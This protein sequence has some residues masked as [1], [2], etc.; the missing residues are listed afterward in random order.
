MG[1]S[2]SN[3]EFFNNQIENIKK[4]TWKLNNIEI[5]TDNILDK[6]LLNFN[7]DKKHL[8]SIIKNYQLNKLL[9]D[10]LNKSKFFKRKKTFFKK[11]YNLIINSDFNYSITRE[12]FYKKIEKD[13]EG[14]A[15]TT[16]IKH[17]KIF[18]HSAIQIFT[19]LGPIA[20]LPVSNYET[21]VVYSMN[22]N[23]FIDDLEIKNLIKNFNLK[24]Q[25]NKIYKI[26]KFKLKSFQLR[27]YYNHNILAF[28]DLLHKIH[29]L[30]GQ[31]F[32]MTLRDIKNLMK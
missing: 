11:N 9:K 13:Y 19:K 4:L 30:A 2:S 28:G 31:G 7:K 15:Y 26:E 8:F 14:I 10:K 32:N 23:N 5:Y 17:K 6:N 1:I 24:Y 22:N 16:F 12:L 25:I 18:N 3:E 29:P 20:F 21:S 27:S